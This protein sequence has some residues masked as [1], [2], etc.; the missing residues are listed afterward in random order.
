MV[1]IKH[2]T[3]LH[4]VDSAWPIGHTPIVHENNRAPY[5][6]ET[7]RFNTGSIV[8]ESVVQKRLGT[9]SI[10]HESVMQKRFGTGSIVHETII[11]ERFSTD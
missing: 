2:G 8:H 4:G 7:P 6:L 11:Q 9:G 3:I 1:S 5:R 10:V